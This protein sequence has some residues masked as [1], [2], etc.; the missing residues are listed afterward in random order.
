MHHKIQPLL[1]VPDPINLYKTLV[2]PHLDYCSFVCGNCGATLRCKLQKLQY[3]AARIITRSGQEVRSTKILIDLGWSDLETR[4]MFQK[5]TIMYEIKNGI[6]PTYLRDL[7]ILFIKT[8]FTHTHNLRRAGINAK[9]LQPK[10]EYYERSP[11]YSGTVL[12]NSL[13]YS[14]RN[15]NQKSFINLIS[16]YSF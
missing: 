3:R 2:L 5:S 7:L 1:N 10:T 14:L 9:I 16:S 13:P 12:W 4:R 15:N 6:A 8:N 11:S